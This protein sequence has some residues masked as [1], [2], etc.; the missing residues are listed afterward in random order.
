M[1]LD[2]KYKNN[3]LIIPAIKQIRIKKILKYKINSELLLISKK[4]IKK[5][6]KKIP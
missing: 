3:I 1:I 5:L 4:L 6:N 2:R